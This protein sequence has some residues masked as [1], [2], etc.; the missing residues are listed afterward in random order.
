ML[1]LRLDGFLLIRLDSMAPSLFY[2]FVS[3]PWLRLDSIASFECYSFISTLWL[4]LS[5]LSNF[6]TLRFQA[7]LSRIELQQTHNLHIQ[8]S[9]CCGLLW[10]SV[11]VLICRRCYCLLKLLWFGAVAIWLGV[12]GVG[13]RWYY[14]LLSYCVSFQISP[15]PASKIT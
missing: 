4:I 1:W 2:G 3:I 10:L 5:R 13:C 7:Y 14:F 11:T 12:T 8:T 15:P 6:A 9:N